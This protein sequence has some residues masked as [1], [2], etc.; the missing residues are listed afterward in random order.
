M[1]TAAV[2]L[3][4]H[5]ESNLQSGAAA[6]LTASAHVDFQIAIPKFVFLR[7]GTGTGRRQ[8]Q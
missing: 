4:C 8:H 7:I 2:P 5:A 3:L 1:M 6:P